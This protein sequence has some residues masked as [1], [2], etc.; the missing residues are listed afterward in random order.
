[1]YGKRGEIHKTW[2]II[3]NRFST[4]FAS[5]R[6]LRTGDVQGVVVTSVLPAEC[7]PQFVGRQKGELL[8]ANHWS[9]RHLRLND[10]PADGWRRR[11]IDWTW[12]IKVRWSSGNQAMMGHRCERAEDKAINIFARNLHD[13]LL[14][15][16][17]TSDAT[18]WASIR[19]CVPELKASVVSTTGKLVKPQNAFTRTHWT[20]PQS[21]G[22]ILPPCV[23]ILT[24]AGD[25]QRYSFPPKLGGSISTI[26]RS[27]SKG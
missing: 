10:T 20:F 11:V 15:P 12:R 13:L 6:A 16:S 8:R 21:G 2:L 17:R 26:P 18:G 1:M 5:H 24:R 3:T 9:S 14:A 19:V 23:K 22:D 7:D 4:V 25:R 27:S